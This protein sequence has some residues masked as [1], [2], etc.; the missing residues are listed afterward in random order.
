MP[1]LI[2]ET[3]RPPT[4][5]R[6]TLPVVAEREAAD[7]VPAVP[8]EAESSVADLV[9]AARAGDEAAWR[10]IVFRYLDLVW[11]V[12]R[13]QGLDHCDAADVTQ[14]TWLRLHE[15]L[16]RLRQPDR[17]AAWLATTAKRESL[18]LLRERR[19]EGA[20]VQMAP[21]RHDRAAAGA[22]VAAE[23]EAFAG[24]ALAGEADRDERLWRAFEELPVPCRTLLRAL[25][26]VPPP[27]YAEL[28]VALGMPIGSIGPTRSRCLD[29]LR[30]S[31][32]RLEGPA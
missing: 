10:S 22:G 29:R 30:A 23:M 7:R 31:I 27:S 14:M 26:A 28:S 15:H 1:P 20:Q 6:P 5:A 4:I 2:Q 3:P 21:Q 8:A 11:A 13:A 25:M 19:R 24:D 17:V 16:D 12:A 9:L 18:K 32:L